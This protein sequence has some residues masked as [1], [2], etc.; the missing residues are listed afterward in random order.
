MRIVRLSI[1]AVAL[2]SAVAHAQGQEIVTYTGVPCSGNACNGWRQLDRASR[3]AG[4]AASHGVLFQLRDDGSIWRHVGAS[5][6][7]IDGYPNTIAI[8]AG[9]VGFYQ[10]HRDGSVWQHTGAPCS[11]ASCPGWRMLD[12]NPGTVGI[13]ANEANLFQL[14]RD[15][16]IW[17]YLG[18]PCQGRHCPGWEAIDRYSATAALAAT[19]KELFQ[20]HRD[21]TIWHFTGAACNARGCPGWVGVDRS[22]RTKALAGAAGSL[23]Q[24][25]DDGSIWRFTGAPCDARAC[26][27]WQALDR[28]PQAVAISAGGRELYQRHRDGSLWRFTGTACSGA[29]CPGWERLDGARGATLMA[30]DETSLHQVRPVAEAPP[31]RSQHSPNIPDRPANARAGSQFMSAL[32]NAEGAEREEAALAELLAGNVPSFLRSTYEI[33]LATPGHTGSVFVGLDYLAIGSDTDFVRMPLQPR[34]AQKVLD[35][36]GCMFPSTKVVDETHKQAQVAIEPISQEAWYPG[37]TDHN[38]MTN[39][40][41]LEQNRRI[42]EE[43]KKHGDTTRLLK[44]GLKKDLVISIKLNAN[45]E[46]GQLGRDAVIIYG[47]HQLNGTIIQP[48]SDWHENTYVDYSHGIRCL[49]P[50]MLVDGKPA[51]VADVLK[52]KQRAGLLLPP[53]DVLDY[54]FPPPARY[55]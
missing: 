20:L 14:H 54:K 47:W 8:A 53:L 37:K 3:T 7:R 1:M 45:P 27:G 6:Q 30:A 40:F 48:E 13:A 9:G 15:G 31:P 10:L 24:L 5:W 34:T 11:G 55:P 33:K 43:L 41:Y 50:D 12:A 38:M 25:H 36:W 22:P 19:G 32:G 35:K 29:R 4:L 44:T 28:N 52:D 16:S 39:A 49:L 17:R 23:Y 18:T 2:H 46:A 51:K 26:P 42:E 21:G